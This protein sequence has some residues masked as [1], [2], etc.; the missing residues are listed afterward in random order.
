[1]IR[2]IAFDLHDTLVYRDRDS[3]AAAHLGAAEYLRNQ[4]FDVTYEDFVAAHRRNSAR[5]VRDLH[6]QNR[7]VSFD[8]WSEGLLR[9]LG[10]RSQRRDLGRGIIE[11]YGEKTAGLT[12]LY[13]GVK[14]M[15]TVLKKRFKL[16]LVS[17]SLAEGTK[18]DLKALSIG[19][20]FDAVVISSDHGVRKPNPSIFLI[21]IELLGVQAGE[22]LFVGD[23][24]KED[25]FG[26]KEVGMKT[27]L[28]TGGLPVDQT[29]EPDYTVAKVTDILTLPPLSVIQPRN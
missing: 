28:V 1:M 18:Q 23:N 7:E 6:S 3:L 24:V 29:A 9:E 17:N 16:G 12:H 10:I 13:P 14:E 4:G 27:V 19:D 25:V 11:A 21:T 2:A 15:L 5:I 20:Y 8:D 26:A 22:A